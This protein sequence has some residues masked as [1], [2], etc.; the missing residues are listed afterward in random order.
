LTIPVG[1]QESVEGIQ[2]PYSRLTRFVR[3]VG[4]RGEPEQEQALLRIAITI[5]SFTY[6][7]TSWPAL[8]NGVALWMLGIHI[9]SAF[10]AYSA[11]FLVVT[12]VWPEPSVTRRMVGVV[13]DVS[14]TTLV[15]YLTGPMGA[16]WYGVYL[17]VTLGN[18]FRYGEK[19]LY[20]SGA[21]SLLGFS[22]V[23][24]LVPY[25]EEHVQLAIGL[26]VTLL[27]IPS[28][29]AILIRRLNEARAQA[30]AA[31]RAKSDFLSRM[32]HEIRTPLNG[33]LGMTDLL[34]TSP[35]APENREYV[36]TIYAS[37]KTL[38][39]QID[40]I[41]DLSKIEA[42]QL[43]LERLE[44]DL[45]ALI[46]TTLRIFEPQVNDKQIQLQERIDPT[47][48]FL[49]LGD[50]HKL[51][52]IIIN[53]VGNAVKFTDHGFVSLRVFPR[54]CEH[55]HVV[56]RFEVADTGGGI[57]AD[58]LD[59]IFEPFTQADNSVARSYGGTGLG[60]TICRHL[61]ELMG[62]E[63]GIRSTLDLG[64]TFWF[65]L[66][67]E[68]ADAQPLGAG[69][70]PWTGDCNVIY[71]QS[72]NPSNEG[73]EKML[74]DWEIPFR[75]VQTVKEATSSL[76]AGGT[77]GHVFDALII[78]GIPGND[79]F[80]NLLFLLDSVHSAASVPMILIGADKCPHELSQRGKAP[81]FALNSPVDK[82]VLLNTLHACY[83][84]RSTEDDVI[85]IVHQQVRERIGGKPLN[86]LIGDDNATNR[87][88]LQRMLEKM[89]HQC[90]SVNGGEAVLAALE[91]SQ[92]D[93]A[94]V[95]K[96]MPDIGGIDVFTT[97]AMAYG[98][99]TPTRF[100][101]LTADATAGSRDTCI[102]AGIKYFLTKP[103]SLFKL[104]EIFDRIVSA[105]QEDGQE[106]SVVD[107]QANSTC[108]F[109]VVD[110]Q[111][112]EKLKRLA[113]DDNNFMHDIVVNFEDDARRDIQA[114]ELA[115]ANR[116]WLAFRDAAHALKGSAM[117]LGFHQLTKLAIAAQAMNQHAFEINGI[118]QVKGIQQ[119]ADR[120]LQVLRE[121]LKINRKFG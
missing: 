55:G 96:N 2:R 121:K 104:Q 81:M 99:R 37:G 103:V 26:G 36:E 95:D 32:S 49:L 40:E 72:E 44:F 68:S 25:W 3:T 18:G 43:S 38:A 86:V 111:E 90:T 102:A 116:D 105:D 53:L 46:N 4:W 92:F 35:L 11:L 83:S 101:I 91:H 17:W 6:L 16:P 84:R 100:V 9:A 47:T 65:D 76:T 30:D 93:V 12:L 59:K 112:L 10:L 82:K 62:G 48:P 8:E 73:V 54:N 42:G 58:R 13:G 94:I 5:I 114:L 69:K 29:S 61:V 27:V 108:V 19:F 20:L 33:I 70:S 87:L 78:D 57:P 23:V 60:T 63:I 107:K 118:S 31:N 97:Y 66:P 15:L 85:H 75:V 1:R 64:T 52:Q 39:H 21:A 80:V 22:I 79:E 113:G 50:P 24:F 110:D 41:L 77:R 89:G 14:M 120:A 51:R 67:F 74:L 115:V 106:R 28:Y 34:R 119:A 56:L 45:Y 117:Y 71:L 88:V 109:P 7:L 98:R